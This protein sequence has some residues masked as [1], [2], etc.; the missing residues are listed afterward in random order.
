MAEVVRRLDE[1]RSFE[2][3]GSGLMPVPHRLGRLSRTGPVTGHDLRLTFHDRLEVANEDLRHTTVQGEP[4]AAYEPLVGS[5]MQER[6]SE[7]PTRARAID[8]PEHVV[9]SEFGERR[10]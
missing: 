2:R 3:P 9:S 1:G 8:G 7:L 6:V 5:L 4:A 10:F